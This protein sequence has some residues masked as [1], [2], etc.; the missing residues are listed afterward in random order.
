[1]TE[2]EIKQQAQ[3]ALNRQ[4]EA[5]DATTLQQLHKARQVALRKVRKPFLSFKLLGGAGAGLVLATVFAFMVST[6]LL[7]SDKLSPFDDLE[8]LTAETDIELY[9]QFEFY[10]WLGESLDEG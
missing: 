4:V 7:Q 9:T 6:S 5:L 3:R 8:M 2:N 1:M 10:E